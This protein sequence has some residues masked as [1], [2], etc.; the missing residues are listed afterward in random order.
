MLVPLGAALIVQQLAG[1]SLRLEQY[2][3]DLE[4]GALRAFAFV[5]ADVLRASFL[6]GIACLVIGLV[7]NRRWAR[8]AAAPRDT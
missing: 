6:V 7:R 1:A 5:L 8:E 3:Q 2:A 4:P